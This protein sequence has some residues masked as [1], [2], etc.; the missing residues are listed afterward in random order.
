MKTQGL[1]CNAIRLNKPGFCQNL[2][3]RIHSF[4]TT[5]IFAKHWQKIQSDLNSYLL[6]N[7]PS[8]AKGSAK[9]TESSCSSAMTG[10]E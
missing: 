1:A 4:P 9:N 3:T 10:G 6:S 7:S 2:F 8:S 5:A